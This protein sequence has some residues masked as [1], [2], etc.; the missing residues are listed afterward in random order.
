MINAAANQSTAPE[1]WRTEKKWAVSADC[2]LCE[3]TDKEFEYGEEEGIQL[4]QNSGL[5]L[6]RHYIRSYTGIEQ[7]I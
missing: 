2:V 1:Q 7:I 3:D 4:V 6:Q 5:S